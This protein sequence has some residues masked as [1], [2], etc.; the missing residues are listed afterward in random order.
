VIFFFLL[1]GEDMV[2]N[3]TMAPHNDTIE[4]AKLEWMYKTG[5][6]EFFFHKEI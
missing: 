2:K 5:N 6:V 4:P 1:F 3:D